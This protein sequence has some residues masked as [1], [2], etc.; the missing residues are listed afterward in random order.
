MIK[1][2]LCP[3]NRVR[4]TTLSLLSYCRIMDLKRKHPRGALRSPPTPTSPIPSLSRISKGTTC[5]SYLTSEESFFWNPKIFQPAFCKHKH[6]W[7]GDWYSTVA[8]EVRMEQ[9]HS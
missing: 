7:Q 8:R 4:Y 1:L 6:R 9:D 2:T 5:F 3:R